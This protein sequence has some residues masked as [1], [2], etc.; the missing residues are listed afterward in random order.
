MSPSPSDADVR[1][2]PRRAS[3]DPAWRVDDQ[4]YLHTGRSSPVAERVVVECST[5]ASP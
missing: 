1:I 5:E 2:D 4:G 3:H